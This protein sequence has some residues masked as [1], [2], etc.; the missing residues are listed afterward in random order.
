MRL[1]N[2]LEGHGFKSSL[3]PTADSLGKRSFRGLFFSK[4]HGIHGPM[5]A[6]KPKTPTNS[7][8]L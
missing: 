7:R 5:K 6:P 3:S 1:F 2:S 4:I 8:H